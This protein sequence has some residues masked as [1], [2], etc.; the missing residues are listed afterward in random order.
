MI[1]PPPALVPALLLL[2][3]P[4]T[5]L[6]GAGAEELFE[7]HAARQSEISDSAATRRAVKVGLPA[8]IYP[9]GMVYFLINTMTT[10]LF[11]VWPTR[12]SLT[13]R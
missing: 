11:S 9:P 1:I 5:E 4:P 3:L 10:A 12:F 8:L 7:L 6:T 13:I 2:A